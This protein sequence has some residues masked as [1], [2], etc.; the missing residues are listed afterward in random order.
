MSNIIKMT[1]TCR[2]KK[3]VHLAVYIPQHIQR[4]C[5]T[6]PQFNMTFP[7]FICVY[8]K[9]AWTDNFASA[10]GLLWIT[11]HEHNAHNELLHWVLALAKLSVPTHHLSL[12][13]VLWR[14][15]F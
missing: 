8:E 5:F 10:T 2:K 6:F 12:F 1:I 14:L 15:N 7:F 4:Q 13:R 9:N 11:H 3:H